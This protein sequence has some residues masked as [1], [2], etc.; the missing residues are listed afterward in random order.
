MENAKLE[1]SL[2]YLLKTMFL[3]VIILGLFAL[4]YLYFFRESFLAELAISFLPYW[5]LLLIIFAIALLG[6]LIVLLWR[7]LKIQD[8]KLKIVVLCLLCLRSTVL[9]VMYASEFFSFYAKQDTM[10]INQA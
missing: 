8:L 1:F 2:Y 10:W 7:K 6:V 4:T 5:M 3:V 9:G